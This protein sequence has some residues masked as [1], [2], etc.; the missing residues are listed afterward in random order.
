MNRSSKQEVNKEISA[1]HDTLDK[2]EI[3]DIYR[4]FHDKMTEY[5]FFSS[6]HG[7]LSKIDYMYVGGI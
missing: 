7:T 3:I 5:T 1:F 4:A 2:M 6:T